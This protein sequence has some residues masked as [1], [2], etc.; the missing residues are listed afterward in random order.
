MLVVLIPV[1]TPPPKHFI[2]YFMPFGLE[3]ALLGLR[4]TFAK[5]DRVKVLQE[6]ERVNCEFEF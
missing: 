2:V 5:L 1:G 3:I 4:V 6:L